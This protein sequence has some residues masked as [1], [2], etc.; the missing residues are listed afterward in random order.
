MESVMA[1]I[2]WGH[3]KLVTGLGAGYPR[4]GTRGERGVPR[5]LQYHI[6]TG[7]NFIFSCADSFTNVFTGTLVHKERGTSDEFLI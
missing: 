5:W 3:S 1:Q 7:Q 2:F 6:K 4:V